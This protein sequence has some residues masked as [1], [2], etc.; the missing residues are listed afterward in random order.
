MGRHSVSIGV[1]LL[2]SVC[3]TLSFAQP[4]SPDPAVV[5]RPVFSP[6]DWWEFNDPRWGRYRTTV[7]SGD[8]DSYLLVSSK[9]GVAGK[10]SPQ[11]VKLQADLDGWIS[12]KTDPDGTVTDFGDKR[13]W[14]RF[15]LT[16]GKRWSFAIQTNPVR[17]N[18]TH[19][20]Y[21]CK[22][23]GW[24]TIRVGARSV[25][26]LKIVYES[27]NRDQGGSYSHTGWYAPEVRQVV[28]LV[29]NYVGGPGFEITGWGTSSAPVVVATPPTI[30]LL[31]PKPGSLLRTADARLKLEVRSPYRL[32]ELSAG[33][34]GDAA[35]TVKPGAELRPGQPW[36]TEAVV[37]LREGDNR[38]RLQATD[39][40][41][42]RGEQVITLRRESV[43]A[44]VPQAAPTGDSEAPRIA[45]NYPPAEARVDRE[46]I[47]VLAL[48]TDNVALDVVT[49]S[50]N[51]T[52]MTTG[53]ERQ[54]SGKSYSVRTPVTLQPGE[55]VVEITAIDK[56]G[57]AT[58]VV[59]TVT[60][61]APALATPLPSI[62]NRWAVVIGVGKYE[63]SQIPSL[64]YTVADAEAIYK[65]LVG[66][67]GFKKDHVLL[68]TDRS[69][70]KPTLKNVKYALGTFLA[71]S[72]Q[73]DD[74]VLIFFAGHGAPETDQRG[75]E[76]DGLAKYLIPSD[77]D[78]EDLYSTAL[79]MDELQTI[80]G[81]LESERIVAFLDA[82]YSG[83][84]GGR[85]FAARKTRAGGV[86]DL[87]LERLTRSKGRAIITASRPAEVSI[88]LP[89][90]GHGI[91]TY[92][93]VEGLKGAADA[94][95]D[96]I[97]TLQELYEYVEAQVSRKSRA[98]GGNQHPVMKGELEGVLPLTR[99]AR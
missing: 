57:N 90:L 15:P 37:P 68:L 79:P 59:R 31:D 80:F 11:A 75:L 17:G 45:I 73:K 96:G 65:T 55:N 39:E 35:T 32:H 46:Q 88:E 38:I 10:N 83:A 70:R 2:L 54:A 56:A 33:R 74:T 93:M 12:R 72:A 25:R 5:E 49:V 22:A 9:P 58:Q 71:R 76:R 98:V 36:T 62:G 13:E 27:R 66:P 89:E 43:V 69:E 86:D 85:T 67:A 24:E 44:S 64:R 21:S 99:V 3:G 51:G 61:A 47:V 42:T 60:R 6:G 7:V 41:G 8:S 23:D 78:P 97:V 20:L 87:F 50:I 40:H 26:A 1:L 53:A 29:S 81:R 82:C 94:N 19:Y 84:A 16:V 4:S 48:V 95:R 30:S 92:Y 14:V 28:R 63:N 91:F 77:A 34:E 52:L 18:R